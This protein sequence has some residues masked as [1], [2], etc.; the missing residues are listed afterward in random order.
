MLADTG[1]ADTLQLISGAQ[2]FEYLSPMNRV[3]TLLVS[4]PLGLEF[5]KLTQNQSN[6]FHIIRTGWRSDFCNPFVLP[7]L[8]FSVGSDGPKKRDHL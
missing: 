5:Q 7:V 2:E 4:V 6:A 8:C 3:M 1:C